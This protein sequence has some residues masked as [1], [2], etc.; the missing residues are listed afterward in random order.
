MKQLFLI[1]MAFLVSAS[2]LLAGCATS[3][4]KVIEKSGK[5]EKWVKTS[6]LCYEKKETLFC[7]GEVSNV[8][9][10]ALGKRQAEAD[11]KKRLVEKVRSELVVEYREFTKGANVFPGDVGRFVEDALQSTS[12]VTMGG[13][14][15]GKS[16]WQS[17]FPGV[18][19]KPYY[20][21]YALVQVSRKDYEGAKSRIVEVLMEKAKQETNKEAER[22]LDEWKKQ[23]GE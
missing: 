5:K 3:G 17:D 21:I 16:Y 7:R 11:A 19:S 14:T 1:S 20:H 6:D 22:L 13:L 4:Y 10:L 18:S 8:Y 2:L 12:E 15:P 23:R 9:D